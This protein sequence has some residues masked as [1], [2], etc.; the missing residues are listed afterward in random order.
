MS[1]ADLFLLQ[2]G[3]VQGY[4]ETEDGSSGTLLEAKVTVIDNDRCKKILR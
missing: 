2:V 3:K 1:C 4:G